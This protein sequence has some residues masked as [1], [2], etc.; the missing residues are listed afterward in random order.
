MCVRLR[1]CVCCVCGHVYVYPKCVCVFTCVTVLV[2]RVDNN[3][4]KSFLISHDVSSI[5]ESNICWSLN[6][7]V[8]VCQH[9]LIFLEISASLTRCP[10]SMVSV[11]TTRGAKHEMNKS[12]HVIKDRV[13]K[14]VDYAPLVIQYFSFTSMTC[15]VLYKMTCLCLLCELFPRF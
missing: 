14:E 1:L 7:P 5:I 2:R 3:K 10:A 11:I 9:I 6:P 12:F 13:L 15:L 4:K 8:C